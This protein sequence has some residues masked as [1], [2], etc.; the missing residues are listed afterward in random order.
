[1]LLLVL[2]P[3]GYAGQTPEAAPIGG[4]KLFLEVSING[5]STHTVASFLETSDALWAQPEDLASLGLHLRPAHSWV[6]LGEIPGLRYQLDRARQA[7]DLTVVDALRATLR[8]GGTGHSSPTPVSATGVVI[9][10][11]ALARTNDPL[12]P[13]QGSFSLGSEQRL[14]S[15]MG[16]FSNTG[17]WTC[18][19]PE[20]HYVR[21]LSYFQYDDRDRL[22]TYQAG[23]GQT[24]SLSWTRP[25]R[26]AGVQVRSNF[27]LD[28]QLLTFPVPVVGS[29]ATVPS[30]IDLYI[31]NVHQFSGEVPSGPFVVERPLALTGAGV[32]TLVVTDELGHSVATTLPLYIDSRL[33]APDRVSYSFEAGVLRYG[34][35]QASSDYSGHAAFSGTY[36]KGMS[37]LLTLE[38]HVE[39]SSDLVATG[40]GALFQLPRAG[41]IHIAVSGSAQASDPGVQYLLGYQLIL[42]SVSLT[43]QSEHATRRYRDLGSIRAMPPPRQVDQLTVS[44]AIRADQT[45]GA[46]Y[47]R[48][49]DSV[50]G[51]A[52][53][54]SVS[55]S[56]QLGRTTS[57]FVSISED[58][59]Q[60]G[61]TGVWMGLSAAL[62]ERTSGWADFGPV[63]R[64][65]Q[66]G[67]SIV[68]TADYSGGWNWGLQA[69]KSDSDFNTIGRA[70]YLG[71]HGELF[72]T[73]DRIADR[74]GLSVEGS[75][76]IV[77]MDGAVEAARRIGNGFALVST[78][79]VSGVAVLHE[80]RLIGTT[81]SGGHLL[82]P[83]LNPYEN[84]KLAIDPLTL[85]AEA[86]FTLDQQ[87]VT[88]RGNSGALAEFHITR[89]RAVTLTLRDASGQ[90]VLP[91]TVVTH[92]ESQQRLV[93]GYDG[94]VFV[95]HPALQNHLEVATSGYA[96]RAEFEFPASS[97]DGLTD[98]GTVVCRVD[99]ET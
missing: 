76:G 22:T 17:I 5:E 61:S 69:Q 73:A 74:T 37:E 42:P 52:E 72:A 63:G 36:R 66:Y 53:I 15:P 97:R 60:H 44:T 62:G 25:V 32:A 51:R 64:G 77:I 28:P 75:G 65:E 12:G 82:V 35:G 38:S 78:N 81:D 59:A 99:I 19:G 9:N 46:S 47:L 54:W 45:L 40:A 92:V 48:V 8:L 11:D 86:S 18:C 84:N 94:E 23:D 67:A 2:A 93:V 83:D 6:N 29:T 43:V 96:C 21:E 98:L 41:V 20:A 87:S 30:T 27:S 85:P 50:V 58:R 39:A 31:N 1:M 68:R 26:F 49:S 56:A 91:G 70:G 24:S 90:F 71:E 7:I 34:Y 79:G 57:A 80:N 95:E 14:F 4:S 88:P 13:S 33:L 10:Y 16:V 89:L 3:K 55:Y